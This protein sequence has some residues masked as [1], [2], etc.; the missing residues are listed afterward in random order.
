MITSN[1]KE[2]MEDKGMTYVELERLTGLSNHTITRARSDS[3]RECRLYTLELI[4]KALDVRIYDL[5][6]DGLRKDGNYWQEMPS[7]A[8]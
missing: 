7:A 2:I 5:F 4:A 3:I 6:Y 8:K 1:V